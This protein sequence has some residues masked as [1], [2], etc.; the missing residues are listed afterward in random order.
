MTGYVRLDAIDGG[1]SCEVH[2]E[3]VSMFERNG[4]QNR[5][6]PSNGVGLA[7][8]PLTCTNACMNE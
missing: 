5:R 1:I 3:H 2:L 8:D 6:M 7:T 4:T